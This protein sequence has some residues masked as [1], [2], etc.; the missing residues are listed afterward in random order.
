MILLK[1]IPIESNKNPLVLANNLQIKFNEQT[2]FNP[3]SFEINNGD[4]VA[5]I[6]KMVLEN[7]VY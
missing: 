5:I 4:R 2:I 1:I 6:G 7:Q 3:I